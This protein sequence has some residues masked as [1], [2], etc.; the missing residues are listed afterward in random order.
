MSEA[1]LDRWKA[2]AAAVC[3]GLSCGCRRRVDVCVECGGP[4]W[5]GSARCGKC[6]GCYRVNFKARA[7]TASIPGARVVPGRAQSG[8]PD[9]PWDEA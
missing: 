1:V 6:K 5:A 4:R 7:T 3:V 2:R 8:S 9:T